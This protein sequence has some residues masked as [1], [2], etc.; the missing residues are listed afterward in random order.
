MCG[1]LTIL[2]CREAWISSPD[3]ITIEPRYKPCSRTYLSQTM[4]PS[5]YDSVKS[6]VAQLIDLEPHI[7]I[8][9][10]IWSSDSLDSYITHWINKDW[11]YKEGCLH[12]LPFNE[13][14]TDENIA[15]MFTSCVDAWKINDKVHLVL[16]DSGSN[17]VA[18]FR[19]IGLLTSS[20]SHTPFN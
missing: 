11:E 14:H 4:I 13:R 3:F 19:D 15:N 16:C 17:F 6:H 1:L 9:T 5:M 7:S 12:A 18:G 2:H 8:T 20:C 10:D